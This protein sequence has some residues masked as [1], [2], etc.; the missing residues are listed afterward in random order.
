MLRYLVVLLW[1][2]PSQLSRDLIHSCR[3][4]VCTMLVGAEDKETSC[5]FA[6]FVVIQECISCCLASMRLVAAMMVFWFSMAR[7]R[8]LITTGKT[9]VLEMQIS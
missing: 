7:S 5:R 1:R 8:L 3:V 2:T 4:I 9:V 6:T